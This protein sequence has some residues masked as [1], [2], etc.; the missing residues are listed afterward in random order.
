MTN[1]GY[2]Y[3]FTNESMPGILKIGM[4]ER[5]PEKRLNEANEH[6][7]W[8]PP[9]PYNFELAKK[10]SDA[11]SKEKKLHKLLEKYT[12]RIHPRREFFRASVED[13]SLFFDLMDGE[14]LNIT[15]VNPT[16]VKGSR[17]MS[18]CFKNGQKIRHKID[19]NKIRVGTYDAKENEILYNGE[20][21][22]LNKFAKSH[23]ETE[24]P[25][26]TPSVNAWKE[27]ECEVDGSWIST[28][29]L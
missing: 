15:C 6:D 4:T 21:Y 1:E 24:K 2:I 28:Y 27:C 10:V 13:V 11:Y 8:R 3:C 9:T 23:Y 19:D 26:R 18:K 29:S 20:Y 14:D 16:C 17:D 7:T 25:D 5:T 12:Y 22:S